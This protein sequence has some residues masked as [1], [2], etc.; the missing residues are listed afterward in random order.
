M[1]AAAAL[2]GDLQSYVTGL[3][4]AM[5]ASA[6]IALA[7]ATATAWLLLPLGAP[8]EDAVAGSAEGEAVTEPA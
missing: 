8:A 5:I 7:G 3:H 4:H 2:G 6:A 1:P